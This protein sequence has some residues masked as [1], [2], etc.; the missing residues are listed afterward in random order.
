M[1]SRDTSADWAS[2]LAASRQDIEAASTKRAR[3]KTEADRLAAQIASFNARVGRRNQEAQAIQVRVNANLARVN[4]FNAT[5]KEYDPLVKR[6]KDSAAADGSKSRS[7]KDD[8]AKLEAGCSGERRLVEQ[9]RRL[10]Q[11]KVGHGAESGDRSPCHIAVLLALTI[12]QI[13]GWLM[14]VRQKLPN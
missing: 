4:A 2:A 12:N 7:L 3:S 10:W 6:F 14:G 13:E 8:L 5:A 9:W 11:K 1:R